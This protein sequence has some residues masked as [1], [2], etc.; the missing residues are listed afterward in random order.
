LSEGS[1]SAT[2]DNRY[3]RIDASDDEDDHIELKYYYRF[4]NGENVWRE[5]QWTPRYTFIDVTDIVRE[6]DD[7]FNLIEL[8][9]EDTEGFE[10]DVYDFEFNDIIG[11][12]ALLVEPGLS[13][14]MLNQQIA[15]QSTIS[16]AF[17]EDPSQ[18][19]PAVSGGELTY[20]QPGGGTIKSQQVIGGDFVARESAVVEDPDGNI[21]FWQQTNHHQLDIINPGREYIPTAE[22]SI[23]FWPHGEIEM[24]RFPL[25]GSGRKIPSVDGTGYAMDHYGTIILSD[26]FNQKYSFDEGY[27]SQVSISRSPLMGEFSLSDGT[28]YQNTRTHTLEV[29]SAKRTYGSIIMAPVVNE[30]TFPGVI[31]VT[32]SADGKL[33][34]IMWFHEPFSSDGSPSG[35]LDAEETIIFESDVI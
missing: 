3:V 22:T 32:Y 27:I 18:Y 33:L 9:V 23:N 20:I 1:V 17:P 16:S 15:E 19:S 2:R 10:S 11:E 28:T 31:E 30:L 25:D 13:V 12:R 26:N 5:K 24:V 8:M 7:R 6:D 35:G 34:K 21:Y 4:P 29:I 14:R